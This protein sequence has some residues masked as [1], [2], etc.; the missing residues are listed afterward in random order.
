MEVSII[1]SRIVFLI[2]LRQMIAFD[3]VV[4]G[5]KV[6][7]THLHVNRLLKAKCYDMNLKEVP[8]YLRTGV[9]I[10][11]LSFNRI[12]KLKRNSFQHYKKV[13]Y[14]LL[15]ENM[16][17]SVEPGTFRAL[18]SLQEIDL[19]N[20]ALMTIPLEIFQLPSLRNLYVDSNELI[21][22]DRDL[23]TLQKPIQA[24]LE[25]INLADCA[26]NDLPDLGIVPN[27]WHVNISKNPLTELTMSKF[28]NMC[29]LKSIDLTKTDMSICSC[30]QVNNHLRFV[31]AD[32]KFVPI[33]RDSLDLN[34]C[35]LP[36]NE[37]IKSTTFERCKRTAALEEAR[38]TWFF[39]AGCVGGGILVL[40]IVICCCHRRQK[41]KKNDKKKILAKNRKELIVSPA[42]AI[43]NGH[44]NSHENELLRCDNA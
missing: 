15:Y 22:L 27:I 21:Y 24:P 20:N 30:Q 43:H 40:L 44:V 8:Q 32:T 4:S 37:T 7:C 33:C 1:I 11:D 17:Q 23:E 26:L 18:T 28:A 42:N 25:Y 6:T 29:N 10:L 35:P 3:N 14:L 39:I 13:K 31:D 41:R 9:E 16:I 38:S 2:L 36:Y 12:K 5:E 19:S 34:I